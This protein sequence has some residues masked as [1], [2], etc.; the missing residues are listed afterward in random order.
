MRILL[1]FMCF[2]NFVMAGEPLFTGKLTEVA[3]ADTVPDPPLG[4]GR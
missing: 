4:C 3:L 2:A 1:S